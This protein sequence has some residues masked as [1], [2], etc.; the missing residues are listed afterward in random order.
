MILTRY[1]FVKQS[2]PPPPHINSGSGI[3]RSLILK[4]LIGKYR[5]HLR[6]EQELSEMDYAPRTGLFI[7]SE[8]RWKMGGHRRGGWGGTYYLCL[9]PSSKFHLPML[10]WTSF[11]QIL[12]PE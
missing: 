4:E 6:K 9:V 5:H 8:G 1:L 12:Q 3:V 2:S 11:Q 7:G 10:S